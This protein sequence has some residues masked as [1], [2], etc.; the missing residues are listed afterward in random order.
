M[1]SSNTQKNPYVVLGI[2]RHAG[3]A[4]VKRAYF[5]LVRQYPPEDAPE[6]F[7]EIRDAYEQLKSEENRT[8]AALFLLQPPPE[9]PK[10]AKG[11]Y[12]LS[13]HQEDMIQLALEQRLEEL[14]FEKD[15]RPPSLPK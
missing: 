9:S 10:V 2:D 15:F 1:S 6:Q 12:D 3:L 7:R 4:E 13:V 14:P 11:R 8:K 5:Q